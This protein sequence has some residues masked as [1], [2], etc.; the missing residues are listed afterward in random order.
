MQLLNQADISVC[1]L[2][3][4]NWEHVLDGDFFKKLDATVVDKWF[5][6]H[7]KLIKRDKGAVC[8][9]TFEQTKLVI[10]FVY[11]NELFEVKLEVAFKTIA[12]SKAKNILLFRTKDL[13][14]VLKA[15][16][17]LNADNVT[18]KLNNYILQFEFT[19]TTA[20]YQINIPTLTTSGK[21]NDKAFEYYTATIGEC[22]DIEYDDFDYETDAVID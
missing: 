7:G 2:D 17:E 9:L 10:E 11:V 18:T 13:M 22:D 19:N 6:T 12:K 3:K 15:V 21:L 8:R 14:P 4:V 20:T 5:E 1:A 16:A